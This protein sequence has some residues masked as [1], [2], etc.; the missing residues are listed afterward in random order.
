MR[1]DHSMAGRGVE[2][3]TKRS[4]VFELDSGFFKRPCFL[5]KALPAREQ[6]TLYG[7]TLLPYNENMVLRMR[8]RSLA[9]WC[10][11]T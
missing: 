4:F 10:L 11:V 3:K 5:W 2:R 9:G 6:S 7:T 1:R 8:I